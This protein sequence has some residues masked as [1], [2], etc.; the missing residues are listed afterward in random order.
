LSGNL[1]KGR[2]IKHLSREVIPRTLSGSGKVMET[3][4]GGGEIVVGRRQGGSTIV[5]VER[6]NEAG[7]QLGEKREVGS[8][9]LR[10]TVIPLT[11]SNQETGKNSGRLS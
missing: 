6:R 1:N 9:L 3:G 11:S 2:K 10:S 4:R 8:S 7:S 5:V